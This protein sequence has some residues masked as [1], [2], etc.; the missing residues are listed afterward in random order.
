MSSVVGSTPWAMMTLPAGAAPA[1]SGSSR[2]TAT[3]TSFHTII[4]EPPRPRGW[5]SR[6]SATLEFARRRVKVR[7]RL[8]ARSHQPEALRLARA[9]QQ[10]AHLGAGRNPEA[11]HHVF[12]IHERRRA[13]TGAWCLLPSLQ[14]IPDE[15]R[16]APGRARR[17]ARHRGGVHEV[18]QEQVTRVIAQVAKEAVAGAGRHV[19]RGGQVSG[20]QMMANELLEHTA[21]AS[22]EPEPLGDH[23]RACGAEHVVLEEADAAVDQA[24]CLRLGDVVKE[25]GELEHLAS[26]HAAPE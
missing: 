4:S 20:T 15:R 23:A 2:T 6:D 25:R 8:F 7:E 18:Q 10:S 9:L 22:G 11:S 13:G 21:G 14:E 16:P 26:S 24:A 12:S 3:M 17:H 1:A 19:A 5:I